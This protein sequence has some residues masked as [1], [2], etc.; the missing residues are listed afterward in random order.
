M[1]LVAFSYTVGLPRNL[2]AWISS[3]RHLLLL[4]LQVQRVHSIG[5]SE[6]WGLEGDML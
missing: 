2:I 3:L 5:L 6:S 1:A 4:L